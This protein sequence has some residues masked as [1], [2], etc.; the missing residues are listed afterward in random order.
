MF[1]V[2]R[3]ERLQSEKIERVVS[4]AQQVFIKYGYRRTT[5]GDLAE[6]GEISRPAL[7][8]LYA[9]KE[10]LF[11]AVITRYCKNAEKL[12]YERIESSEDVEQQLKGVMQTWVVEPF[13]EINRSPEAGEIY[14]AGYAFADDLREQFGKIYINQ[15]ESVL[16]NSSLVHP[17]TVQKLGFSIRRVAEMMVHSTLGLKRELRDLEKLESMLSDIRRW[18]L[19]LLCS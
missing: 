6:A 14:E 2:K 9:N 18:N 15:V 10:A 5:M 19:V 17:K 1:L 12:A 11:R 4:A 13:I 7:Y 8:L 16:N 3:N